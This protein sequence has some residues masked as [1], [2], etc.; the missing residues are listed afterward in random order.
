[1]YDIAGAG[2]ARYR[3]YLS[4]SDAYNREWKAHFWPAMFTGKKFSP[5]DYDRIPR[6]L[7]EEERL[8]GVARRA[9]APMLALLAMDS[10]IVTLGIRAYR[11]YPIAG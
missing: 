4:Q 11:R 6:F 3:H 1:L 10:V 8:S 9:A 2:T 5:A 7:G